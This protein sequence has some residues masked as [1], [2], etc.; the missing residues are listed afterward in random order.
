MYSS[1]R[2]TLEEA[3][4]LH[5]HLGPW[6]TIGYRAGE[7]AVEVLKPQTEFD[8]RCVIKT[9]AKTPY[10]CALDGIQASTKCT[11]GKLSIKLEHVEHVSQSSYLFE[12]VKTGR[13]VELKL[14]PHVRD[15]VE[16]IS[17]SKGMEEA[18][19]WV[20][21]QSLDQLFEEKS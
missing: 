21:Q 2:L 7:R 8:L 1:R 6:L 3:A 17:S 11:L 16:E 15:V 12:N 5:G 19:K 14:K 20:L 18:S 10:T 13:K 9:P 4:A